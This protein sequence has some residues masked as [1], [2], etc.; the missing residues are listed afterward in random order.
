MNPMSKLRLTAPSLRT[1]LVIAAGLSVVIGDAYRH[2]TLKLAMLEAHSV[3]HVLAIRRIEVLIKEPVLL[4]D[5]IFDK[6]DIPTSV[7]AVNNP[8]FCILSVC[9]HRA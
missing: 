9:N 6:K 2:M 1:I 7:F 4:N 3:I 8:G 5:P